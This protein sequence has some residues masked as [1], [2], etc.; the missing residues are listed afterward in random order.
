MKQF[1]TLSL[2]LAAS[3]F[4]SAC[5]WSSEIGPVKMSAIQKKQKEGKFPT[6]EFEIIDIKENN[7]N[8]FNKD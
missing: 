2:V 4:L 5:Q 1:I 6:T 3:L 7:I 8:K